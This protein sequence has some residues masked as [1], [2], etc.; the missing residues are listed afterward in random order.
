MNSIKVQTLFEQSTDITAKRAFLKE[1]N[2]F[3]IT[4]SKL[5]N[6]ILEKL[7]E[8][9]RLLEPDLKAGI[10][11]LDSEL[12]ALSDTVSILSAIRRV[13]G[14]VARVLLLV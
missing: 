14:I 8:R 9:L 3:I 7:A 6:T 2:E 13:T 11:D 4:R 5:E 10:A 12:A 1:R